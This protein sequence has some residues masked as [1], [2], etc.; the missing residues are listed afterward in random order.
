MDYTSDM[1]EQ[2]RK[3]GRLPG[4][5]IFLSQRK[6]RLCDDWHQRNAEE[7]RKV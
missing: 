5:D 3:H 7:T 1:Q 2:G 4:H 6:Q